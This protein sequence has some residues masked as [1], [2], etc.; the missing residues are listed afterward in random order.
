M[1]DD[2]GAPAG[3]I[4]DLWIDA[5]HADQ[6]HEQATLAWAEAWCAARGVT[7]GFSLHVDPE[8]RGKRYG[9][10][11]MAAGERATR[12]AGDTALMFTVWGGNEVAMNLY[13]SAGY[14][15][16]ETNR[17]RPGADRLPGRAPSGIPLNLRRISRSCAAFTEGT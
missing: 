14:R 10:G 6:G 2:H 15:I 4:G 1:T 11:A 16:P 13:D 12:A 17:S 7:Y 3:R 5:D 8:H 9:H